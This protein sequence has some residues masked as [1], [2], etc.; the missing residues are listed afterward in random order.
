MNESM[1]ECAAGGISRN[2][3]QQ[4]DQMWKKLGYVE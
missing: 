2:A 4:E 1:N 3:V